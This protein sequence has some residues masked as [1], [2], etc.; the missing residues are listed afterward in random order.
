MLT[1]LERWCKHYRSPNQ[2][3]QAHLAVLMMMTPIMML[4]QRLRKSNQRS[5]KSNSPIVAE[6]NDAHC[7]RKCDDRLIHSSGALCYYFY[8]YYNQYNFHPPLTR[9]LHPP[10]LFPNRLI[11]AGCW[12][13]LARP[14]VGSKQQTLK[15]NPLV[16]CD[17]V[18]MATSLLNVLINDTGVIISNF[19]SLAVDFP[20]T[21]WLAPCSYYRWCLLL[22]MSECAV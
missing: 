7:V 22:A 1:T 2:R 19:K 10:Q 9:T 14:R 3:S 18:C 21:L 4:M 16:W 11:S 12:R 5:L 13:K 8:C 15:R 20:W 6:E 17:Y